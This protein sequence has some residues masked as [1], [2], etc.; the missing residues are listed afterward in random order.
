[1][2]ESQGKVVF[3]VDAQKAYKAAQNL[4]KEFQQVGKQIATSVAGVMALAGMLDRAADAAKRIREETASANKERGS[5]ELSRG[6][7]SRLMRLNETQRKSYQNIQ[8]TGAVD[9]ASQVAFMERLAKDGGR[10]VRG[11]GGLQYAQAF[12]TGAFT[13]E[14]LLEAAKRGR[15]VNIEERMSS[16]SA[17]ERQ[18]LALR[19]YELENTRKTGGAAERLALIERE[20]QRRD[21]PGLTAFVEGVEGAPVIGGVVR[22]ASMNRLQRSFTPEAQRDGALTGDY[23]RPIPVDITGGRPQIGV[24]GE[25]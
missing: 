15:G 13:Q 22:E 17:A 23:T 7:A 20:R 6:A 5:A 11:G 10:K 21:N 14:E 8:E 12:A 1:M 24:N 2:A 19:Q 16:L 25:R 4:G 3:D 18:E 9:E